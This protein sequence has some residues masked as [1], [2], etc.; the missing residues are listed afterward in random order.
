MK[1]LTEKGISELRA[2]VYASYNAIDAVTPAPTLLALALLH[3]LE[4]LQRDYVTVRTALAQLYA[5]CDPTR[6]EWHLMVTAEGMDMARAALDA[7]QEA[8]G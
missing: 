8:Q 4:A 6:K 7:T 1:Y 2:V 5:E 3:E